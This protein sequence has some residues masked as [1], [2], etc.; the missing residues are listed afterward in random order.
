MGS[1]VGHGI[2]DA[3]SS[4]LAADGKPVKVGDRVR[5]VDDMVVIDVSDAFSD[6]AIATVTIPGRLG[7][8]LPVAF[9]VAKIVHT[10]DKA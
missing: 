1:N 3:K 2:A 10:E 6:Y 7:G 9:D 4:P 5:P 8:P